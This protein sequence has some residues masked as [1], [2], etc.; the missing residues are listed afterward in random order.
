VADPGNEGGIRRDR[1]FDLVPLT[2][3]LNYRWQN[4]SFLFLL[5]KQPVLTRMRIETTDHETDF[6]LAK[7]P[8]RTGRPTN[9]LKDGFDIE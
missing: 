6:S 4:K 2:T 9:C 5:S 3:S 7:L 1:S 8:Q